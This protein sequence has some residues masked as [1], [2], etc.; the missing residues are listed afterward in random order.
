MKLSVSRA[1]RGIVGY[2][3]FINKQ[4]AEASGFLDTDGNPVE[5]E[6]EVDIKSGKITIKRMTDGVARE[7]IKST[8]V[9]QNIDKLKSGKQAITARKAHYT[10]RGNT[11]YRQ[12]HQSY[13]RGEVAL[14]YAELVGGVFYELGI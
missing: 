11:L 5:V 1:K 3:I 2:T 14:P 8:F 10:L 6:K 12:D 7:A 13:L 4:E 9:Y